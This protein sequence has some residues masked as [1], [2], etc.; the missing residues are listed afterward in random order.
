MNQEEIERH[1][2]YDARNNLKVKVKFEANEAEQAIFDAFSAE[3]LTK[4]SPSMDAMHTRWQ[5]TF[6]HGG[7]GTDITVKCLLCGE[8]KDITDYA[9]W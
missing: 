4:C 1:Q 5:F 3:H 8:E 7:V 9:S 2:E 6:T